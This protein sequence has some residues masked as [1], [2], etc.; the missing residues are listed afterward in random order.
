MKKGKRKNSKRNRERK[1]RGWE[2]GKKKDWSVKQLLWLPIFLTEV[3]IIFTRHWFQSEWEKQ[4]KKIVKGEREGGHSK[5]IK[6]CSGR[7]MKTRTGNGRCCGLE[8]GQNPWC[9]HQSGH[10]SHFFTIIY[11]FDTLSP[12]AAPKKLISKSQ[13]KLNVWKI[14]K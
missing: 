2:E 4:S 7:G 14:P 6:G 3:I 5:K 13:L 9:L 1:G 10:R 11:N 8:N 12:R